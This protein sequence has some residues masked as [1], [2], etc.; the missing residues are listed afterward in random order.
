MKLI[1]AAALTAF[2]SLLPAQDFSHD[3]SLSGIGAPAAANPF[4]LAF[5]PSTNRLYVAVA[6]TFSDSN[7]YVAVFDAATDTLLRTLQVGLYPEDIAFTYDANGNLAWGAVTNSSS[8]SVTVWDAS[9]DVVAEISLPDPLGLGTCFPFGITA[10]GPGF[11]VSTIDGTGDIHAIDIASMSYHP[12]AGIAA[13]FAA[14]GRLKVSHG[15]VWVPTTRYTPSWE[16]SEGGLATIPIGATTP[17][18][19]IACV[20]KDGQWIYFTRNNFCNFLDLTF[21]SKMKCGFICIC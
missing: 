3:I 10:G 2:P 19:D 13:P 7:N 16:G 21:S 11:L 1:F 18:T 14:A 5:E 4:G 9:D 20:V 6:G 8:G 12:T 15:S 17:A